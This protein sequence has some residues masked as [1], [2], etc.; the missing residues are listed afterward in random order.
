MHSRLPAS[1]P[2]VGGRSAHPAVTVDDLASY[3]PRWLGEDLRAE[4]EAAYADAGRGY[5]DRRHLAEVLEHVEELM[6]PDDPAREAV[7]LAAWFHD[8]V[9]ERERDDEERSAVRAETALA[10]TAVAG[11]VARLVRLTQTHRP[12]DDDRPGQVLC[13]ADLAILAAEPDRYASY[14]A[15]VRSEYAHV[16]AAE[17]AVGRA[18]VLRDLL[19][20]PSLFHTDTARRR[21]EQRARVHVDREISG[22]PSV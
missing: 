22:M 15:G 10:G 2:R 4:L 16:P 3:W 19:A 21:W 17:F 11:E 18:A 12:A 5:H 1:V 8:V 6:D 9:Y 14:V 13:D 20:K 7:L